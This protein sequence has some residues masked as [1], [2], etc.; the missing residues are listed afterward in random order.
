MDGLEEGSDRERGEAGVC[1]VIE[2]VYCGEPDEGTR[3]FI[4]CGYAIGL[5]PGDGPRALDRWG[6]SVSSPLRGDVLESMC[7]LLRGVP[8]T[9]RCE[10]SSESRPSPDAARCA[11]SCKVLPSSER[12]LCLTLA[13]K[14]ACASSSCPVP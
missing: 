10:L 6:S 12:I 4:S 9:E 14:E 1:E 3:V 8:G 5:C 7:A 13:A 11:A 2:G